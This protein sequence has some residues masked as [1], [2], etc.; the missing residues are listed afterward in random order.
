MEQYFHHSRIKEEHYTYSLL[1]FAGN[2]Y[3]VKQLIFFKMCS[4]ILRTKHI[5]GNKQ[6]LILF[7]C[8]KKKNILQLFFIK[9]SKG[10]SFEAVVIEKM[11]HI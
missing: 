8:I 11:G 5:L 6:A 4:F 10:F 7:I 9:Q 2:K 1:T 3:D